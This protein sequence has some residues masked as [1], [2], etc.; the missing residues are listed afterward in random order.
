MKK[1]KMKKNLAFPLIFNLV[2]SI[3]SF[4]FLV[5]ISTPFVVSSTIKVGEE[6]YKTAEQLN[7]GSKIEYQ[8]SV[9]VKEGENKWVTE[10]SG[11]IL[12]DE[13]INKLLY[14]G[15]KI[16][17]IGSSLGEPFYS[18]SN[19]LTD[20]SVPETP[21]SS[22]TPAAGIFIPGFFT[23]L[24]ASPLKK[25]ASALKKFASI[26]NN[27]QQN[28]TAPQGK[29]KEQQGAGNETNKTKPSSWLLGLLGVSAKRGGGLDSIVAGAEWAG[30][31]YGAGRLIG[32]F[33]GLKSSTSSSISAALAAGFG[34]GRFL[35]VGNKVPLIPKSVK[36]LY[37]PEGTLKPWVPWAGG[38]AAGLIVL[39]L[40]YK[41]ERKIII[42]FECM[43]W[44]APSGGENCEKCNSD[45]YPCSEYRCK[46]LGQNCEF[47]AGEGD[48]CVWKD[49][50]DV[51]SPTIQAWDDVL[52]PDHKYEPNTAVRPPNRGVKIIYEKSTDGCVKA[53]TPLTFGIITN[54][55]AQ[56]K[57]DENRTRKYDDMR[58]YFG[59]S[60]I[61]KYNHTQTLRLPSPNA[62]NAEAPELKA[63]GNYNLYVRCKDANGNV[64]EDLFVFSFCVEKGPDVTPPIIEGT[65]IKNEMPIQYGLNETPLEVY[66][67]EPAECRWSRL[68][69]DYEDMENEMSCDT[70][71]YEMNNNFL[72]KCKTTLTGLRDYEDNVFY[73]RCKDQPWLKGTENENDRNVN[74]ESYKFILKGSR[75]LTIT[76]AEPNNI[77][78]KGAGTL[79]TVYLQLVTENG[80]CNGDAW[81]SYSLTTN[82]EDYILM[83]ETSGYK[84]RQR[85]DLPSGQ[86]TYYFQCTDLGGNSA[87]TNVTF[88]VEI[89]NAPPKV[90]RVYKSGDKLKIITDE[91]AT[92]SYSN[93]D[94]KKCNFKIEEGTNMPY[95]N[96]T[97]H[98]AQW[99]EEN[100]YI[101]CKDINGREPAPDECSIIVK[102]QEI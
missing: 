96:S 58:Y 35:A 68:D 52:S 66:V 39:A 36:F 24:M 78:I 80:C 7:I 43:P 63:D 9:Y 94:N 55:P 95:S 90:V 41:K 81:C 54:E 59:G 12:T 89:D 45:L 20:F 77:T 49:P 28:I 57:I 8:E 3:L 2:L 6:G 23:Q 70:R 33:L 17:E 4:S 85:L 82:E 30:M 97:E 87:W 102:P 50:R 62:I 72:Y 56:C 40:T 22:P 21:S 53:F 83:Y 47:K 79:A 74:R 1:I 91:K 32:S 60:N 48:V 29:P 11:N 10:G 67:N 25:F 75:Q 64:N 27:T 69:L 84:H 15:A 93:N 13:G 51:N 34:F 92:C 86:Y 61:Y 37:T 76:Q 44:E 16:I 65:S 18:P 100:Y 88:N 99:K 19:T 26:T 73:F 98:V 31:A 5:G 71:V 38:I 42:T 14:E 101:K 46:S